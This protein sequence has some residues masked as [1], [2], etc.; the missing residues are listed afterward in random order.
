MSESEK[1]WEVDT[2]EGVVTFDANSLVRFLSSHTMKVEGSDEFERIATAMLA[3]L[4]RDT[5]PSFSIMS[6]VR[7]G[8][9][10]GY[11]YKTLLTKNNV[12]IKEKP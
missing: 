10:F 3:A 4:P 6:L 2:K 9:A 11:S 1:I 12:K 7:L 5:I 8:F